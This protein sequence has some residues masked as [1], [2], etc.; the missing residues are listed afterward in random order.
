MRGVLMERVDT[1]LSASLEGWVRN[2]ELYESGVAV[3]PPSDFAVLQITSTGRQVWLNYGDTRPN[4]GE[5]RIDAGPTTVDS[6]PGSRQDVEWRAMGVT[7]S[8]GV[9]IVAK[10]LERENLMIR[11]LVLAQLFIALIVLALMAMVG[12]LFIRRALTPLREVELTARAIAAGDLDRRVPT[13]PE[14]T[15]VGR[16]SAALNVMLARLQRSI[17][18]LQHKEEQMRRFIGDASHE[19]RTPL[20]SVRGYTELYRSGATDDVDKVFDK[21]D[22]ESGRM[23]LLVEDLLALTRAEGSR[24]SLQPVDLLEVA[25]AARGSA[26]AAFAGRTVEVVNEAETMPVVNGDPD[27]LHQVLLNLITNGLRHAGEDAEVTVTLRN[28]DR[29]VVLEVQDNGKGMAPEVSEHIFERFYREDSSRSRGAGGGSGLG[30]AIV[31]SLVEQHGGTVVVDSTLGEGSTF[32]VRLPRL[33][34]PENAQR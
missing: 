22:A 33:L 31:K 28:D 2:P 3:G 11:A 24:L 10:S 14:S 5:L 7:T 12:A 30:L 23:K 16:L 26:R 15:E 9:T 1:D 4:F 18:T 8:D 21:I 13:W 32:R 29:D 34:N 19:L 25:L 6:L 20:T 27:R 17:E